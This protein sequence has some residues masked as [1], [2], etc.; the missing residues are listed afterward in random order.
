M[1]EGRC[2]GLQ[3]GEINVGTDRYKPRADKVNPGVTSNKWSNTE[4]FLQ[5]MW[6]Q[7]CNDRRSTKELIPPTGARDAI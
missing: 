2:L 6:T 3:E 1:T 7:G 5:L 4:N